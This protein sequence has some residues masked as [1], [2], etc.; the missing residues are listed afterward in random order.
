MRPRRPA[1][2]TRIAF[3]ALGLLIVGCSGAS[4]PERAPAG[5]VPDTKPAPPVRWV[6]ATVPQGTRLALALVDRVGSDTSRRGDLFRS[7]ITEALV[8][9]E[10]VV[11]PAGSMVFGV[12]GQATPARTGFKNKGGSMV[13]AFSRISTPTGAGADLT[14]RLLEVGAKEGAGIAAAIIGTADGGPELVG[15]LGKDPKDPAQAGAAI[16]TTVAAGSRGRD[17]VLEPETPLAIVLEQPLRIKV[18][19]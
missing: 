10:M 17:A 15:L 13:L 3:P 16:A 14:A 11:I 9:G 8:Q 7:R 1:T 19:Q 12:V 4:Q 18:H 5:L 2:L 6:D